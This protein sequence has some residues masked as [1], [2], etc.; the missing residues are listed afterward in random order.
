MVVVH[1]VKHI[2]EGIEPGMQIGMIQTQTP[3]HHQARYPLA[4]WDIE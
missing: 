3:M 2:T 1:Q 4:A